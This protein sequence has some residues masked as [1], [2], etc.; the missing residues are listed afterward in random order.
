MRMGRGGIQ[1]QIGFSAQGG[2]EPAPVCAALSGLLVVGAARTRRHRTGNIAASSCA[3]GIA[4][5]LCCRS[6]LVHGLAST[7]TCGIASA[8]CC[9]CS[10]IYDGILVCRVSHGRNCGKQRSY[11]D[12]NWF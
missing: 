10:L 3:C 5:T 7:S 6:T 11:Q 4:S 9:W 8:L 2:H 12:G 1:R